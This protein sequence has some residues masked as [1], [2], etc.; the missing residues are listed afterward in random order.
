MNEDLVLLRSDGVAVLL[1]ARGPGLPRIAHWGADPGEVDP[2]AVADVLAPA[3]AGGAALDLPVPVSVLPEAAAGFRGRPGLSGHRGGTAFA[4]RFVLST[5]EVESGSVIAHAAD[6]GA[7]LALRTE[8]SLG[9][10]GILTVRHA[11]ANTGPD[12]YTVDRLAVVLPL[13]PVAAELL[14]LTG[15]WCLER[16]PQRLPF[17]HG[18]W[19]REGRH[20]R[21]GHDAPL[22]LAAGTPG[23][24]NRHGELW[25]VHLG[26]SGDSALWAERLPV[27]PPVLGAA[28]LLG[29]GE[30]ILAPGAKYATPPVYA[31]WS[32]AGLDGISARFHRFLRARAGHPRRPRPVVL[33]TWEAVYFDHDLDR[34]RRLADTAAGLGVER[35]VLDDGWFGGRRHDRA[36]LG[37]WVV[38]GQVWPDG[39]GPLVEH[40]RGL[41]ME[42]GLWVEPEMVNPDSDLYRAHPDWVLGDPGRLPVPARSQQ[43]LDLANPAAYQHIL[44][45]VDSLVAE[46]A[47]DYLKWDHNRDLVEAA[48]RGRPAVRAQTLATYRML[49]ELRRRHPGLEIESCASGGGRVD[50]GILARADRVWASDSNDALD[51][52]AIQRWTQLLLPPELVGAHVGARTSHTTGRTHALSFRLATALVGHFGVE[53][54]VTAASAAERAELARGIAAYK[55]LRGLLHTGDLVHADHP[56]PGAVLYGVVGADRSEAAYVYARLAMSVEDVPGPARLPGLDPA[57]RYRIEPLRAAGAVQGEPPWWATGATLTGRVLATAGLAMPVLHPEHAVLLR[58]TSA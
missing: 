7:G 18:S 23:F 32:E 26:W 38:S 53:W 16:V 54:D 34:L 55:G 45:R 27:S 9:P 24:G 8:I 39:L 46:Y 20:G 50:L 40:V 30:V 4:P 56:D 52:Q 51:R 47:I 37:D 3:P 6:V 1:D 31:A 19:V 10:G 48:H 5:V 49:D 58:L 14:D 29:P 41:G 22:L 42:F 21:T 36:G 11:L 33:N 13:P 44:S 57:R 12:P 2:A 25:G 43:V 28:E 35:F 15:R 17:A